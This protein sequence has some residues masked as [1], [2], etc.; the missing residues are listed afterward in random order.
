MVRKLKAFA[1]QFGEALFYLGFILFSM[2]L[3]GD[4]VLRLFKVFHF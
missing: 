2:L 4:F 1:F 3:F